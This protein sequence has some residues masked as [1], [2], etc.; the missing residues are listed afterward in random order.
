MKFPLTTY[1]AVYFITT[2]KFAKTKISNDLKLDSKNLP[3]I[4]N[5]SD[6]LSEESIGPYPIKECD[7]D[8]ECLDSERCLCQG[9]W[10]IS[11]NSPTVC[12]QVCSFDSDC[13][14]NYCYFGDN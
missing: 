9:A 11:E 14:S 5:K 7:H 10:C 13:M 12:S 8:D 1:L 4:T 3:D 6:L 2:I